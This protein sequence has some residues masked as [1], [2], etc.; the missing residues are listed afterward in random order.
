LYKDVD[1]AHGGADEGIHIAGCGCNWMVVVLGFAGMRTAMQSEVLSL[2]PRLP[3]KL[4]R[5]AFPVVW[6]GQ[7]VFIELT[8]GACVVTNRSAKPLKVEVGGRMATVRAGQ[9]LPFRV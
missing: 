7:R 6:K 2:H 8:R 5:I 1:V 4:R 9:S 3:G